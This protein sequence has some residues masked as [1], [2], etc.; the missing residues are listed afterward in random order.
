M[1]P[2][3]SHQDPLLAGEA[4]DIIRDLSGELGAMR[5]ELATRESIIKKLYRHVQELEV[6]LAQ[7]EAKPA[8]MMTGTGPARKDNVHS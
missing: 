8:E 5:A 3:G 4:E 1:M 7:A 2:N 6:R